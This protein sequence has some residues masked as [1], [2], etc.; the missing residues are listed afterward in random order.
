MVESWVNAQDIVA[1]S[2]KEGLLAKL[3]HVVST[4]PTN[5]IGSVMENIK[6][7]LEFQVALEKQGIIFAAGPYRTDDEKLWDGVCRTGGRVSRRCRRPWPK[8]WPRCHASR[9]CD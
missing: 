9:R 6:R 1:L 3:L 7:H 5:G 4:A 2:E 8:S